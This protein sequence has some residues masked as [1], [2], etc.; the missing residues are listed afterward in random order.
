MESG[1]LLE[2]L[3]L[4]ARRK[5]RIS[6]QP[7]RASVAQR[8][9]GCHWSKEQTATHLALA[10]EG[11]VLQVPCPQRIGEDCMPTYDIPESNAIHLHRH[12]RHQALHNLSNHVKQ[13]H[14]PKDK[15]QVCSY[16]PKGTGVRHAWYRHPPHKAV[17]LQQSSDLNLH[18]GTVEEDSGY[19]CVASNDMS[20]EESDV[21]SVQVLMP[22]NSSCIYVVSVPAH[23]TCNSRTR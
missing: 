8:Y 17:L 6:H 5:T 10:L 15:V 23:F 18:C 21:L 16:E 2:H 20:R 22:A 7:D 19:H 12:Q 3:Q 1:M 14:N 9:G 4:E 13:N 11:S